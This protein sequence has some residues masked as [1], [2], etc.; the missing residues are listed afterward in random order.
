LLGQSNLRYSGHVVIIAKTCLIH[1]PAGKSLR[2]S[3]LKSLRFLQLDN[4]AIAF[5]EVLVTD[6]DGVIHDLC[7]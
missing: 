2:I 4:I 1:N 3:R 7:Y 6:V 5:S